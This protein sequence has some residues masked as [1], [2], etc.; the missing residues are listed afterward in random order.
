MLAKHSVVCVLFLVTLQQHAWAFNARAHKIAAEIAWQKLQPSERQAIVAILRKHP[1]FNEDFKG[2]MPQQVINQGTAAED[3]W[4][5]LQAAI[6]PD[7]ARGIPQPDRGKYHRPRW[8]YINLPVFLSDEQANA[9]AGNLTANVEMSLPSDVDDDDESFNGVQAVKNS[10]RVVNNPTASDKKKAVHYC[11][12]LHVF[13][14]L[15]QPLHTAAVFTVD[16]FPAGDKGGNAIKIRRQGASGEGQSLHSVWDGLLGKNSNFNEVLGGAQQLIT[17]NSAEFGAPFVAI[18][19]DVWSTE[20]QALAIQSAYGPIL[21]D[22]QEAEENGGRLHAIEVPASYFSDSG[23]VAGKQAVT[24]GVRLAGVLASTLPASGGTR[25]F[26]VG[27]Q[28]LKFP[29]VIAGTKAPRSARIVAAERESTGL[30]QSHDLEQRVLQL[31]EE[32][33]RLRTMLGNKDT[34]AIKA[35]DGRR[36]LAERAIAIAA[37]DDGE[38]CD[39]GNEQ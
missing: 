10:L 18:P 5:F 22:I 17:D 24:A 4:I 16:L 39:C 27:G 32:V 13:P 3:H 1:R 11:W 37:R 8:H 36:T 9:F 19:N 35:R 33:K 12:L 28:G 2:E 23:K 7:I 20:S 38:Q 34:R 29:A 26:A 14:D 15:A 31:E 30:G 21:D 25:P 6:W